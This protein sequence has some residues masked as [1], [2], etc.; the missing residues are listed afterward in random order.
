MPRDKKSA[1]RQTIFYADDDVKEFLKSLPQ[2]TMSKY[3][4]NAIRMSA[5]LP[6]PSPKKGDDSGKTWDDFISYLDERGMESALV[7]AYRDFKTKS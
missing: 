4:N 2:K 3:I 7:Q 1:E 6:M 5:T